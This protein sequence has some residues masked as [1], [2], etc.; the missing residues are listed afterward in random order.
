MAVLVAGLALVVMPAL[1]DAALLIPVEEF[2]GGDPEGWS[3]NWTT[4]NGSSPPV[5]G[6]IQTNVAAQPSNSTGPESACGLSICSGGSFLYYEASSG[7]SAAN[8]RYLTSASSFDATAYNITVDFAYNMYGAGMGTLEMQV[9]DGGGWTTVFRRSGEYSP[10]GNEWFSSQNDAILGGDSTGLGILPIDLSSYSGNIDIRFAFTYGNVDYTSDMA[11]DAVT[12]DGVV[13][14]T[15]STPSNLQI[16]VPP[17]NGSQ[18]GGI[19]TITATASES[20]SNMTATVSGSSSCNVTGQSMSGT[21]PWTYSW[22]TSA[23]GTSA[24]ESPITITVDGNEPECGLAQQA[25]R[26]G[27]IIDNTGPW[28]T[29][30]TCGDCHGINGP[31]DGTRDDLTRATPGSHGAHFAAG[32]SC[33]ECHVT[34]ATL[35]HREGLIEMLGSIS[36]GTYSKGTSWAQTSSPTPLGT[37]SNVYCH[38]PNTVTAA[39]KTTGTSTPTWGTTYGCDLCHD[40]PPTGSALYDHGGVSAGVCD[41]CHGH[42]GSGGTH[43]DGQ[44]NPVTMS[45]TACHAS[46]QNGRDAVVAEFGLAWGHKKSGRGAVEDT[47]CIVCHLEGNYST[48]STSSYHMDGN[49]DLR[50][51]DGAGETPITNNSGGAFTFTQYAV[52]YSAG[53]RTTSLGNSVAE[54]ITVKFC[55]ACHDSDGATNTTARTS[56]GTPT[57]AMPFGGV[58]LGSNYNS[59]NNAIGT[60]GLID[61]AS[62]FST[63]MTSR[64]PVGAPN[65]R[66]YPY[67]T[68]L[69][70][71]YN[72]IGTARNSNTQALGSGTRTTANSVVMVCD[73]CHTDSTTISS[74][75]TNR[76][77]TAHGAS[78]SIAGTYFVDAPTLCLTCHIPLPSDPTNHFYNNENTNG[79]R[80]GTGSGLGNASTTRPRTVMNYCNECHFSQNTNYTAANRP[81]YAQDVHGFDSIYGTSSGWPAGNGSG[82]RPIAFMRSSQA[83]SG[84]GSWPSNVSPRPYSAPGIT[85]GNAT[86]GGNSNLN[87]GDSGGSCNDNHSTYAPGGAY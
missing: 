2:S 81:R 17:T 25:Q 73:D 57:A 8:I 24:A 38:D 31:V 72:N 13:A 70:V 56:Y 42:N 58:A 37:C 26:T 48:Q 40:N 14:C 35:G 64:H 36:G 20:M 77:I 50:D 1:A 29:I 54:V 80:H 87:S 49:I 75:V 53:A 44:I 79:G 61:V 65:T 18:V 67:S 74:R 21:G 10:T 23:C 28:T 60:Q 12:I 59:T 82:M 6:D 32:V 11:I 9:N 4:N 85:A 52:S 62:Q 83:G 5:N 78:S 47:D 27:I 71:P 22:D 51:P 34:N 76:T 30:T 39:A 69:P 86:C 16:T 66:A 19:V 7:A 63:S 43:M 3:S 84:G 41:G 55:M 15:D 33:T 46:S 68:R 45:C